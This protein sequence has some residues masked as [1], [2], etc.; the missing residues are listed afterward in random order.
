[1]RERVVR[2]PDIGEKVRFMTPGTVIAWLSPTRLVID[3][4]GRWL[5]ASPEEL[6]VCDGDIPLA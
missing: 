3:V 4:D 6:E 2:D 5:E 1:M